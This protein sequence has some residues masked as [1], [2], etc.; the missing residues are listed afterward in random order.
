MFGTANQLLA[1]VALC[2]GTL[3][4]IN[5]GKAKYAWMTVVPMIFVGITTITAGFMN[6]F[7]IY[8]P[9]MADS[10]SRV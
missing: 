1:T 10:A 6:L 7:N 9:Q 4:I 8:I 2:I 5:R 3:Y